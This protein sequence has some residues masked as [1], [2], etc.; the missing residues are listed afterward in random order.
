MTTK[1]YHLRAIE[2]R[3]TPGPWKAGNADACNRDCVF[4]DPDDD[5]MAPGLGRVLLRANP[6]FPYLADL[7]L[8]AEMRNEFAALLDVADAAAQLVNGS[9]DAEFPKLRRA[10]EVLEQEKHR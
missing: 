9:R 10:L 5:V 2:R 4:G 6:N 3:A 1:L 7:A 8:I